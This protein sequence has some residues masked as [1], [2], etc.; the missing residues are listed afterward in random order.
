MRRVEEGLTLGGHTLRER[1]GFGAGGEVWLSER[2]DGTTCALKCAVRAHLQLGAA[3]EARFRREFEQLRTLRLPNV[4]RVHD[5]G[6]DDDFLWFTMDVARGTSFDHYVRQGVGLGDRVD[7]LLRAGSGVARALAAIHRLGLAHRDLKPANLL[8][9]T[10]GRPT[11]LDFGTARFAAAHDA[12]SELMGTV[13]YMA[14]EQRIGLPHDKR[15]DIY[16]FGVTLHEALTGIPAGSWKPGRPRRSL[17]RMGAEV[18]RA[19]SWLVDRML[20]LDPAA[21]PSATEVES[22][23]VALSEG[24]QLAPAPWPA[25]PTY[26]GDASALLAASAVVVGHPGTGRRRM[27]EE[28]RWQWY[29]KGYRSIAGRCAPERPFGPFRA[30]LRELFR[31]A[32]PSRQRQ[33]ADSDA[34]LLQALWPGLPLPVPRPAAWPPDPKAA[35]QALART[36]ARA[37][38]VAIVLWEVDEADVGTAAVLEHLV[39]SVP[40]GVRIWATARRTVGGLRQLRPPAWSTQAEREVLPELI[41]E[42]FWPEGPPGATP[43]ESCARGWEVLA[44][45]RQ[46]APPHAPTRRKG[47]DEDLKHLAL[48]E[49]PFPPEVARRLC[50]DLDAVIEAGHLAWTAPGTGR[51]EHVQPGPEPVEEPT[52]TTDLFARHR[53]ARGGE[54]RGRVPRV[55]LEQVPPAGQAWL[56]F[57]D[58]GTRMLARA[59]GRH[60][61]ELRRRAAQAW[62]AA[63]PSPERSLRFALQSVRSGNPQVAALREAVDVALHRGEPAEVE[64]WLQLL[65][66]HGGVEDRWDTRFASLFAASALRPDD[67]DRN[68]ILALGRDAADEERRGK[69]GW[70]LLRDEVRRGDAERA[71]AQGRRWSHS[72]AA[73]HPDLASALRREAAEAWRVLGRPDLAVADARLALNLAREARHQAPDSAD[74]SGF[75]GSDSPV[76]FAEV[77]AGVILAGALVESGDLEEAIALCVRMVPLCASAGLERGEGG[78][79]A[80]LARAQLLRGDRQAATDTAARCR[81][82]QPR[83]RDPH[84]HAAAALV[85]ARLAVELGDLAAGDVLLDEARTAARALRKRGLEVAAS[86]VALEAALH[87]ADA[88]EARRAL[89][90]LT[91]P[92]PPHPVGLWP[93]AAARWRWMRGDLTGAIELLED[94]VPYKSHAGCTA[95]AERAR[96]LLIAGDWSAA[97]A[98]AEAVVIDA[99]VAGYRELALFGRLVAGA[100]SRWPEDRYQELVRATRRSRQVHLYLGALHLDAIRRRLRGEPVE[101]TLD[102]LR[103]RAS[104][105]GHRLYLA[106]ARSEGW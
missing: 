95:A 23:L 106:L 37:A 46:E 29:R 1:L 61:K 78:L 5:I 6:A 71:A 57:A 74:S 48:L 47:V 44:R 66:L 16:A 56:R 69:A 45:Y 82:R 34:P 105:L 90:L 73:S 18:D 87:R 42:G 55:P 51:W 85:R 4:V 10:T 91:D 38:P 75:H 98:A 70:L 12:S 88:R 103:F 72:L 20:A 76:S 13:S 7:R 93:T 40:E 26:T 32:S 19:L 104:D 50:D 92:T 84:I 28:A 60:R 11:V 25:P 39:R 33:L 101:A 102:D 65:E 96:L 27:V 30:I 8:V 80:T 79:L 68:A 81:S 36:L 59:A 63:P 62:S 89:A 43:L 24:G 15:V 99:T 77:Q 17:C 83:H 14:P 2:E 100:V 64:R 21:R 41:P 35:A 86:A 54:S 31:T 49:D 3:D 52:E 9:D 58:P 97:L 22:V 67:I 94:A 53:P